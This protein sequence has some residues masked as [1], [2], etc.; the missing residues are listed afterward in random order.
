MASNELSTISKPRAS[1][2]EIARQW[3]VKFGEICQ[4][5]VTPSLAQIWVEHLQDISP[6]LLQSACDRVAK[7]WTSG[8]LPTPGAI[9]A[10]I[11]RAEAKGLQ[12]EVENAWQKSITYTERYFHPDVGI[13]RN[14][15]ELSAQVEHAIRAAGGLHFL[16]GCPEDDLQWAKKRFIEAYSNVHELGQMEYLLGAGIAKKILRRLGQHEAAEPASA[17]KLFVKR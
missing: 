7:T 13:S 15:P 10:V 5:E 16:W 4:R 8:F 2:S 11:D 9:R 12:L 6:D 17:A 14:A 3:L 1:S